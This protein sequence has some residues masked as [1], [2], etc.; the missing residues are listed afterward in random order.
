MKQSA[1]A[2]GMSG[3]STVSEQEVET[4]PLSMLT[5]IRPSVSCIKEI[6]IIVSLFTPLIVKNSVNSY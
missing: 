5:K 3:R 6:Q 2:G 1:A 4:V